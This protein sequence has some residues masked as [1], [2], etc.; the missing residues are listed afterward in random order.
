MR[1]DAKTTGQRLFRKVLPEQDVK[2]GKVAKA[3][4]DR[5]I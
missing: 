3:C 4:S 1:N 5:Q 2:G